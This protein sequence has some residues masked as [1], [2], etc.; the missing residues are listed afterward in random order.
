MKKYKIE[1]DSLQELSKVYRSIIFDNNEIVSK[2][3]EE[4]LNSSVSYLKLHE[5]P[6]VHRKIL[7]VDLNCDFTKKKLE[8]IRKSKG[9]I[10][11]VLKQFKQVH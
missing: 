2:Y 11:S 5:E 6:S 8:S 4:L 3:N 9:E 10:E 7:I 1:F